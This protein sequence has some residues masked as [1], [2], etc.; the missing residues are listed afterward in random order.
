MSL[1]IQQSPG[2]DQSSQTPAT[3]S[4]RKASPLTRYDT[5]ASLLER[6]R[7][8]IHELSGA[9]HQAGGAEDAGA[10]ARIQRASHWLRLDPALSRLMTPEA[11]N[12]APANRR[13]SAGLPLWKTRLLQTHIEQNLDDSLANSEL[14][15]MVGLGVS[16]FSRAFKNSFGDSPRRYI[17]RLR[18][19]RARHLLL[20][21]T[22]SLADIAIECGFADQPHF[23]RLFR[24]FEGESPGAWRR[25]RAPTAGS[26]GADRFGHV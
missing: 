22:T 12:D 8:L 23:C 14:A 11:S 26:D 18:I 21:T 1:P 19:A 2:S 10:S 9:M 3:R 4:A 16:H 24:E 20:S 13:G 17:L 5:S 15:R 7:I 6:L 25:A